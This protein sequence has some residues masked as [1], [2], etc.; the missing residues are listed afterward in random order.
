MV[1][2]IKAQFVIVLIMSGLREK[3]CN[4]LFK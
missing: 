4:S 2:A 3:K 1:I